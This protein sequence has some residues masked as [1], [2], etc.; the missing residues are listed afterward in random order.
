MKTMARAV[1]ATVLGV[2][3]VSAAHA[4]SVSAVAVDACK[5][6]VSQRYTQNGEVPRVRFS[7]KTG[8]GHS[9]KLRIRV[10]PQD[11]EPFNALCQYDAKQGVVVAV[12]S[13]L[14]AHPQVVDAR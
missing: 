2:A 9:T 5:A 4:G 11:A 14:D 13:A 7:G 3:T 10:L 1:F 12:S 6:E 8:A